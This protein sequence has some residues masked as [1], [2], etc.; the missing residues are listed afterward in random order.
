M[1]LTPYHGNSFSTVYGTRK[2]HQTEG[3]RQAFYLSGL[4]GIQRVTAVLL[5]PPGQVHTIPEDGGNWY[6]VIN[7]ER[8]PLKD[9]GG[10]KIRSGYQAARMGSRTPF[11][12]VIFDVP[13][14][15]LQADCSNHRS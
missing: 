7:G 14:R 15:V 5:L 6:Y 1:W 3:I 13:E 2:I 8:F 4:T 12:Y 11:D 9:Y 10:W